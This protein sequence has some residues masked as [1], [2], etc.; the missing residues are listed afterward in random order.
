MLSNLTKKKKTPF[1]H[2]SFWPDGIPFYDTAPK[3]RPDFRFLGEGALEKGPGEG[4]GRSPR[5]SRAKRQRPTNAPTL[6]L[7]LHRQIYMLG[8]Y[9]ACTLVSLSA[10]YTAEELFYTR[11]FKKPYL[12]VHFT[13]SLHYTL[14]CIE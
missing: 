8:R 3:T 4:G 2:P 7:Y 5:L 1:V 11:W 6:S 9:I 14:V 10:A 13:C 12:S